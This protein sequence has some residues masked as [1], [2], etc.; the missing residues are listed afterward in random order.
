LGKVSRIH[1]QYG[2]EMQLFNYSGRSHSDQPNSSHLQSKRSVGNATLLRLMILTVVLS[3]VIISRAPYAAAQDDSEMQEESSAPKSSAVQSVSKP[4]SESD[5]GKAADSGKGADSP[6]AVSLEEA[7][8]KGHFQIVHFKS[9][10][11]NLCGALFK[12]KGDGPYPTIIYNHGSEKQNPLG[13]GYGAVGKFYARHGFVVLVPLRR[14]HAFG[15]SKQPICTSEGEYFNDRVARQAGANPDPHHKNE[16]WLKQQDVDN[17]DV[18]AAVDWLKTQPF[19]NKEQLIMSG[20]S[21]GG[22]QTVL[23]AEKGMGMKAF[24]PFAPGAMSWKGVPE[25]HDRLK[26]ALLAAKAPVFL[27]QAE[28]DYNTGPSTFLGAVLDKKGGLN[29]HKL[30]PP[31]EPEKGHAAGHGG[32]ATRGEDL[33][34][35][36]VFAFMKEVVGPKLAIKEGPAE[37]KA[38][39]DGGTAK[40]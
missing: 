8:R 37:A 9:G 4:R 11:L 40:P 7:E 18:A 35:A 13:V 27:I 17:S 36:D 12:P 5:S 19:V 15:F 3:G 16:I 32:F 39:T 25:L 28:N 31:F 20:I 23:A 21:F 38:D 30:Y 22:I 2:G 14:G 29:R 10:E 24:I 6:P 34:S 26:G 1:L 33:W